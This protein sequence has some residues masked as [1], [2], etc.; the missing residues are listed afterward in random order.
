MDAFTEF[1]RENRYRK[2]VTISPGGNHGDT[3]IHMGLVKKL[4]EQGYDYSS[5]NLESLYRGNPVIGGKYLMNIFLWKTGIDA[6]FRLIEVPEDVELVL[7]DGGGYMNDVWYGPALLRAALR[8]TE[9]PL[10][11]GPQSYVFSRTRI[12][13]YFMDG[14]EATLFCRERYSYDH[15]AGQGLPPNVQLK[16]SPELALY[17]AP[18]DLREYMKPREERYQL[19]AMRRDRESAV[20]ERL[21]QEIEGACDNPVTRDISMEGSLTDFVSWVD[22]AETVYTDRLHVAILSSILGKDATLYGNRYHKNRGVW[23]YSL[24]DGVRFVET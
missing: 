10:A 15:L 3:L 21:L 6:G 19:V 24:R 12:A 2:T 11:V 7:F 22:N 13:D 20:P 1:L 14:R 5:L 23:E 9:A 4:D 18:E 16:V 8:Q 17:L